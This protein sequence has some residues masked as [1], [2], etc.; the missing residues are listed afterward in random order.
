MF[1]M[2]PQSPKGLGS[3]HRSHPGGWAGRRPACHP[4]FSPN[5]ASLVDFCTSYV[6][7]RNPDALIFYFYFLSW[8]HWSSPNCSFYR[9]EHRSTLRTF[10]KPH[11]VGDRLD[12]LKKREQCVHTGTRKNHISLHPQVSTACLS[13]HVKLK[14]LCLPPK[15]N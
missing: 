8:N 2:V 4:N 13:N 6:W 9:W 10:P 3:Y 1:K 15:F 14:S 11:S 7:T 5:N 12:M